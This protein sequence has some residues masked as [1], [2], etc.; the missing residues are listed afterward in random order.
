LSGHVLRVVRGEEKH[1][2]QNAFRRRHNSAL[3]LG[4]TSS[5]APR[6]RSTLRKIRVRE[7]AFRMGLARGRRMHGQPRCQPAR[8][9]PVACSRGQPGVT[10]WRGGR[11]RRGACRDR[12]GA[13]ES[14]GCHSSQSSRRLR[15]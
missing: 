8:F 5:D 3:E 15:N 12:V 6:P 9:D 10:F 14:E 2:I 7:S 4:P 11:G 13:T 1:Y